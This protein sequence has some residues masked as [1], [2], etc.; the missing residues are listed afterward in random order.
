MTVSGQRA[1]MQPLTAARAGFWA[2]FAALAVDGVVISIVPL[3]LLVVRAVALAWLVWIVGGLAYEIYFHGATGR[4]PGK[5]ALRIRVVDRRSGAPI[6]YRRSAVRAFGR[7][8]S[9]IPFYLGY[10]WMLWDPQKQCWHDRMAND[11]VV[12]DSRA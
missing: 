12:P 3:L 1:E 9:A 5:R 11:V 6:G 10:V 2:R 7:W 8:V 4:T